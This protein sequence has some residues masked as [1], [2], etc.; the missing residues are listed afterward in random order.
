MRSSSSTAHTRRFPTTRGPFCAQKTLLG[1]TYVELTP[2]SKSA[3][4]L[5]EGGSL[6][7]AQVASSVQLDEVFRTFG[8]QDAGRL[9]GVDA[10]PRRRRSR[11]AART[12]ARPLRNW[13]RSRSQANRALRILD[14]QQHAVPQL[15][16]SG[17]DVFQALSERQGQ[18]R[19][20]IQNSDR[21]FSTT[22]QP[23]FRTWPDTVQDPA[24]VQRETT[25]DPAAAEHV[26]RST[27]TL[28]CSKLRPSAKQ[29][30][31]TFRGRWAGRRRDLQRFFE[32]LKGHDRGL[33]P[34]FP[35]LRRLLNQRPDAA[36]CHGSAGSSRGT[37]R[38][39]PSSTQSSRWQQKYRHEVTGFRGT[40]QLP[41]NF[42]L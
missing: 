8:K 9:Q 21:V 17:G 36:A 15:V 28:W 18:L 19:S 41:R 27:P 12:S 10:G 7:P 42:G 5:P 6:P 32:G 30:S 4:S 14:T 31:P 39:W 26:R 11:G 13:S 35:A 22:A 37:P 24:D 2:G 38:G 20:L 16:R 23:Q 25:A 3:P 40:S 33:A 34:G 1:E 29:L